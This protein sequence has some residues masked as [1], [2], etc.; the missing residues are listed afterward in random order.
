MAGLGVGIYGSVTPFV[1]FGPLAYSVIALGGVIFLISLIGCCG[2]LRGSACAAVT[3][4]IFVFIFVLAEAAA[5]IGFFVVRA[6]IGTYMRLLWQLMLNGPDGAQLIEGIETAVRPSPSRNLIVPCFSHLHYVCSSTAAVT[7]APV[8]CSRP[9]T[10]A[11]TLRAAARWW[12]T[13]FRRT[14]LL[15][16]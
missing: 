2:A 14:C 8:T 1:L 9:A 7:P 4:F 12:R 15:F 13:A 6:N 11:R 5:I 10:R 3:Y 16:C